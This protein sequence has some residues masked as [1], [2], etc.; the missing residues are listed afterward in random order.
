MRTFHRTLGRT[1]VLQVDSV[2]VLQRAHYVPL[3]SRMGPYDTGM[4][5]RAASGRE[6]R[7][8]VEYWAHVQA[9]M[10]VEL[11]PVMQHRMAVYREQRGKWWKVTDARPGLELSVLA[12]IRD[13]GASTARELDD[14]G[15]VTKKHWGWNWSDTRKVLDYLY[16]TGDLAIAGRNNSFEVRYDLPERV[17][18]RRVLET[19]LPTV[20]EANRELVRRAAASH[21]VAT[22]ACLADYY[23]MKVAEVRPAVRDLVEAGEL[24]P[25]HVEGWGK[26]AYLHRE[27]TVPRRVHARAVLSPFDPLVW[28]R[29]RTEHLFDFRYRIEIY[30]PAD[31][32]V[33]G[34]YVLPFLLEDRLVGR[35][36]LKADRATGT[37]VV[38]GAFREPDA[39]ESTPE[40]LADELAQ[41]AE[42]LGLSAILVEG[43]G[44]LAGALADAVHRRQGG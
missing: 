33:H 22:V 13:Q 17:L 44:D 32:R 7:R 23:R 16:L 26:P 11:W 2:N 29:E 35:V 25:V 27:V 37:L 14:G 19:P 8:L 43:R 36:D 30:V 6:R 12:A 28:R 31:Q 1:G 9:F 39:P 18:P 40:E 41:V 3:F 10:P 21:G 24:E 15:P 5:E 34:Y 38:R 20:E 42:W 4:L